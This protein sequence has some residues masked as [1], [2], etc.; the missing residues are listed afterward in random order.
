MPICPRCGKSL[1][2]DQALT[3]HLNRKYKCGHWKCE[4]CEL[5]FDTKFDLGIHKMTCDKCVFSSDID[6]TKFP[7]IFYKVNEKHEI[8]SISNQNLFDLDSKLIL[9]KNINLFENEKFKRVFKT[10]YVIDIPLF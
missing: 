7:C 2:T 8:I 10:P 6:F 4:K 1:S 5:N 3:Y 9:G